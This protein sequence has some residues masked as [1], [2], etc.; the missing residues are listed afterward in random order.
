M[1]IRV[2]DIVVID[3]EQFRII[4]FDPTLGVL[5][6]MG[7][8]SLN[9]I[10]LS[11]QSLR[12]DIETGKI[13]YIRDD[14]NQVLAQSYSLEEG[15]DQVSKRLSLVSDIEQM[16]GPSYLSLNGSEKKPEVAALIEKYGISKSTF[17]RICRKHLQSGLKKTSVLRKKRE[18]NADI[19]YKKKTGKPGKYGISAGI[20]VDDSIRMAFD[21]G[22]TY[23]K[24]GRAKSI[25]VAYDK[26]NQDYFS[27]ETFENGVYS[28]DL[29]PE[30]M[31]PTLRQFQ[32]YC[33]QRIT[34]EEKDVIKTSRMEV[35]N[36]KRLLMGE[37]KA[38]TEYPGEKVE[39]D[40]VEFD[41]S[42]VSMVDPSQ[43]IG[44]PIVY[45][46]RDVLTHAVVAFS[47]ALDNNSN[48]G[49]TNLLIN[50][51]DDKHEFCQK[52][53]IT[54]DDERLW[55]SNFIPQELYA[56]RGSDF[57]S[58]P[59]GRVCKA[60]GITR[61]LVSGGSGSLKGTIESWFHQMHTMINAHTENKGLIEKRYD[62]KHHDEAILDIE[63][64]TKMVIICVLSYNQM[65]MDGYKPTLEQVKHKVDSTPSL[66]WEFF[67]GVYG[68]PRPIADRASFM[69]ELLVPAQAKISRKGIEFKKLLFLNLEDKDL[70]QQMYHMQCRKSPIEIR[71][72][73]RDNS[74]LYYVD[75]QSRFVCA[76]LN[77]NIGWQKDIAGFT[78]AETDR[79]FDIVR[80]AGREAVQR[81]DA[82]RAAHFELV[83]SIVQEA[84]RSNSGEK[85]TT[86][87]NTARE[88]EK[89]IISRKNA[90]TDRL[91][92]KQQEDFTQTLPEELP[93]VQLTGVTEDDYLNYVANY[94][95]ME[96]D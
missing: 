29:L 56:D 51:G 43:T 28:K 38:H 60:L 49:L 24:S 77:E 89:Q 25:R 37:G 3:Q 92:P 81:N 45:A 63:G 73:P 10:E 7:I 78:W 85:T 16:F 48:I 76:H 70:A 15:D 90:I 36:N 69:F 68:G 52:Y 31:R 94:D 40:A 8:K 11:F 33:S 74:K 20:I 19:I 58:D 82:I 30:N 67:C 79:Y 54:L 80:R 64:F 18:G 27:C 14:D 23:Y 71:Y 87:M 93:P 62:S 50:L 13:I 1:Q 34:E 6:Q 84:R 59:F 55:P 57:K 47:V 88:H 96:D 39:C 91:L 61:H 35:R 95:E 42:L 12:D 86:G 66:L 9:L 83:E 41:L 2:G 72:D 5:C 75:K 32:Y 21:E 65:H 4:Y 44:R 53:G 26:I 17:W 22:L 46:M